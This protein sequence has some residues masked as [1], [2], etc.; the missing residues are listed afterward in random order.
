MFSISSSDSITHQWTRRIHS[1]FYSLHPKSACGD[2][3]E[4]SNPP[5]Y[6][7]KSFNS[8][9]HDKEYQFLMK[10]FASKDIPSIDW[11][12]QILRTMYEGNKNEESEEHQDAG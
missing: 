1:S 5:G 9:L 8:G 11:I 7:C 2:R 3:P 12:D 6:T 4:V 10:V